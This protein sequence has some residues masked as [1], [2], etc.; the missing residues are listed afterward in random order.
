MQNCVCL[1]GWVANQSQRKKLRNLRTLSVEL[2][3]NDLSRDDLSKANPLRKALKKWHVDVVQ[4]GSIGSQPSAF[5]LNLQPASGDLFY[6]QLKDVCDGL[7]T[8][9]AAPNDACGIHVHVSAKDYNYY[10]LSN[11]LSLYNRVERAMFDMCQAYRLNHQYSLV[12]G[13]TYNGMD[14][15][16][17]PKHWII[18]GLYAHTEGLY[19]SRQSQMAAHTSLKEQMQYKRHAQR[20]RALNI[21]SWFLRG[22]FEFRHHHS[23]VDFDTVFTWSRVCQELVGASLRLGQHGIS[24][25]PRNSRQALLEI[26]PSDLHDGIVKAWTKHDEELS[27]NSTLRE[28]YNF[29]WKIPQNKKGR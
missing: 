28:K 24:T 22:T 29:V 14:R 5:E 13:Q 1:V 16:G 7:T 8:M 11:L 4:D 19:G 26:M 2:E 3:V 10:D 20:Y 17:S 23:T 9:G 15:T 18:S 25:L 6:D 21:H 27:Q 12:C